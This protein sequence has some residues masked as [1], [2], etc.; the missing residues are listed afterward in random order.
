ML[1]NS[2]FISICPLFWLMMEVP[3]SL[4]RL[5]RT[6][7][8]GFYP[9]EHVLLMD[10]LIRKPCM[11]EEELETL[12]KL[13][14]KQLRAMIAQLKNDKM[15]K[16]R[17]RME[18]GPDGKTSRQNYH[19]INYR[20]FVNVV[21][22]KLD[23]MRRKIETE[24]RDNTS[25]AS[26]VCTKCTKTY[27]D[28]ET[29]QLVD[30]STGELHCL[31]C[32]ELVEEDPNV[33]PKADSRLILARFNEQIEPLYILL[34]EVEDI[35][36][37]PDLLE[38]EIQDNNNHH[39]NNVN[40]HVF[41]QNDPNNFAGRSD[42]WSTRINRSHADYDAMMMDTSITVNI[43]G[44]NSFGVKT[45][46]D[47]DLKP[48]KKEQPAWMM[49]TTVDFGNSSD[50]IDGIMG[51]SNSSAFLRIKQEPDDDS[52][53]R[54]SSISAT[55][56]LSEVDLALTKEII[57]TLMMYEKSSGQRSVDDAVSFLQKQENSNH[58]GNHHGVEEED[59]EMESE[60]EDSSIV[61]EAGR[62]HSLRHP[63]HSLLSGPRVRVRGKAILL[64][65]I[66]ENLVEQM[67]PEEKEE[68]IRLTQDLYSHLYD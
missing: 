9:I 12:L 1:T 17:L 57:E 46:E 26:F 60:G 2:C 14:R 31:H 27:T 8:R 3:N 38:P 39:L 42:P 61:P 55:E 65:D 24:E 40:S 18:T 32:G 5:V 56:G 64:T 49:G 58:N 68:Y 41:N 33:L 66:T 51:S 23:H 62:S 50:A 4:K 45:E 11:K 28:L 20:A 67:T 16:A 6:V 19:Y 36:L 43:Q 29:G 22:Y 15:I 35:V 34:K 48:A 10:M 53:Q 59:I 25:R 30:I 63:H 37:P 54:T 52:H 7:L 21:K 47:Q 44:E 13:E